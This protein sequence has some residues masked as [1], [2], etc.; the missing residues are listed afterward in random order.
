MGGKVTHVCPPSKAIGYFLEPITCLA[1]FSKKP[2]MLTLQGV[3]NNDVDPS[4]DALRTVTLPL[5][6]RFGVDVGLELKISK[7]GAPPLGGGE[8]FFRC[9]VVRTLSPIKLL[10]P[11]RIKRVRGWCDG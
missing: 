7:R 6:R 8:V 4:V 5:L 2:L 1:P 3:T 9:P 11:G 10:E